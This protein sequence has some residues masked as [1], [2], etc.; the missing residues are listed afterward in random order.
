VKPFDRW[1][2]LAAFGCFVWVVV[3]AFSQKPNITPPEVKVLRETVHHYDTVYRTDTI[4]LRVAVA[5]WDTVLTRDTL[6]RN[7][8]VFVPRDEAVA[9]LSA[10]QQALMTCERRVLARDSLHRAELDAVR[11]QIP[12]A[13]KVWGERGLWAVLVY[14]A[15]TVR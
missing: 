14:A 1:A 11:A 5:R 3:F 12:P 10:C 13:W 2:A 15:L 4:R 9:V 6:T 7:D 8:T